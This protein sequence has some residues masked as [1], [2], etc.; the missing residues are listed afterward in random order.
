MK[1]VSSPYFDP[2]FDTLIERINPPGVVIDNETCEDCTL[3]KV[4]SAN[5]HGILLEMVQVLTDLDLVISKSYISSDG[6]WLMDVFHVTDQLGN[7]LTDR[8]LIQFIR[9]SL[10]AG[11]RGGSPRQVR[12]CLGK[13]VGPGRE[14]A[15]ESTVVEVTATDR[16]G[17]LSEIAAVLAVLG[18]HVTSVQ[19]WT[20][21]SRAAVILY[22]TDHATGEP[23]TDPV[24]LADIEEQ[25][26][27]VVEA[28][29]SMPDERR[30]VSVSGPTP[31]RV[32]T[33]RRLHQMMR[34]D[35]DYET[36]PAPPPAEADQFAVARLEA[37]RRIN[38]SRGRAPS[39][40][41]IETRVL[42]DSWKG[43]GYSVVN[44]RSRDRPKL[45]FDTVCA[46]TDM[47]Y[48]V[49]HASVSSH[50]PLAVQEY[51]IRNKAGCALD[52]DGERQRVTRCLVAAVE[53]RVSHGLRLDLCTRNRAGLLADVTRILRENGLSLARAECSTRG[54]RAVGTFYVTDISGAA[55]D[56]KAVEVARE[57]IGGDGVLEVGKDVTPGWPQVKKRNSSPSIV[58]GAG[59]SNS[60]DQDRPRFSL[61][62][63]LWSQIGRFS[64]NFGSIRS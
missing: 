22:V 60:M 6:G 24:S 23:I 30:R 5:R 43:R 47:Q 26:D 64:S 54:E 61:G 44:I 36:G 3:V 18:C 13:L 35:R 49:F 45:L 19:A 57:E 37:K 40:S 20:H 10:V 7:Q 39:G 29:V 14:E 46:L 25:V 50:G 38:D 2:E 53:R 21:N 33:E 48:V 17:L 56:P 11:R 42:I 28:R 32:H 34:E 15:S 62:S 16:P 27:S 58:I 63:L 52:E 55:V 41:G 8:S 31:G 59:S 9:Q 4:D 51:Y 1:G 12:T